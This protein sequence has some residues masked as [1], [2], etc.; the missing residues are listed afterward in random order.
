[1]VRAA[2]AVTTAA[3]SFTWSDL[4]NAPD[5][6][7]YSNQV[8]T[9]YPTAAKSIDVLNTIMVE[10]LPAFYAMSPAD[11]LLVAPVPSLTFCLA[12]QGK[13]YIVYS[14]AGAPFSLDTRSATSAGTAD[15]A[16][17][18]SAG[19]EAEGV[20]KLTWFDPVSGDSH[21]G[22]TVALGAASVLLTPPTV[23]KHWVAML[24]L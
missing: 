7:Y 10:H 13:Q 15:T 5:D 18:A 12:E 23:N 14:D 22:G 11:A 21:D 2:W 4:G 24:L 8:F 1:M 16:V 19:A 3:A 9:T 6:P 20:L 17:T